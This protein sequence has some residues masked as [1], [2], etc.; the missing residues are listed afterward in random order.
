MTPPVVPGIAETGLGTDDVTEEE[1]GES[2]L[3]ANEAIDSS[4]IQIFGMK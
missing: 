1:A 3:G 2:I 4:K